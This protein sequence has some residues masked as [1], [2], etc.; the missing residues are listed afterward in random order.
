M[1]VRFIF[2]NRLYTFRYW[3]YGF[4]YLWLRIRQPHIETHGMIFLGR[5]ARL[6]CRRGLGHMEIGRW[7]WI[8]D[9]TQIR[10]HEGSVRI[11]D[12]VVFGGNTV[13]NAYLDIR[14]GDE[15]LLADWIY[16]S[17]FDHRFE[18]PAIPI[19]RQGIVK[20]PVRIGV[21]C[22]IG[23]KVSVLRGS[24]IGDLSVVG[25]QTVVHGE[26][27][28]HSVIVGSPGRVIRRWGE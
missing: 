13:V 4:R 9:G 27:P 7:V 3:R 16:I 17:D 26:Y 10:C 24:D 20:S 6:Y 1:S 2:R 18:N 12:K 8:G 28:D 14:I 11:G 22:W 15:T 23:E 25:A 21:G 19:R 5:G